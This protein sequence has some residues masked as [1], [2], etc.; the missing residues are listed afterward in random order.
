MKTTLKAFSIFVFIT[1]IQS[2]SGQPWQWEGDE[3]LNILW[4]TCEDISPTLSMYGDEVADTPNLDRL[5][6]EGMTYM[7]AFAVHGV[8]APARSCIATGMY[9]IHMGTN[10]MRTGS[11]GRTVIKGLESYEAVPP[12]EMRMVSELLRAN[13]YYATNN[14]KEDYQFKP[15]MT[16]WDE[17]SG[18]A[19]YKNRPEGKPFFA[20]FNIGITHESNIWRQAD[21]P[22]VGIDE[23]KIKIASYHPD[24][25]VVRNDY[26]IYY[27]NIHRMDQQ[28][29]EL[30][31]ELES[32][33]LLDNTI[34]FFYS[35]HGGNLPREKRMLFDSGLKVP[36]IVRFPDKF[37]QG[38]KTDRLV[39]FV[40]FAPTL[41]S[42]AGVEPK[43][44]MQGEA[45]LGDYREEEERQYIYA[46]R[47]RLD[48][49]PTDRQRAVR[50][51][52][53]K[54]IRNYN[55][56]HPNYLNVYY[57]YSIP[58]MHELLRLRE[59]GELTEAQARWF[60]PN[61]AVEEL[62]DT[63]LDPDEVNNLAHDKQ[64]WMK[65]DEMRREN[66]RFLIKTGDLQ[67]MPETRLRELFW[68][69]G[70]QP[71]TADPVIE[72]DD[73]MITLSSATR[74]ASIGYRMWERNAGKPES[75]QVYTGP[76]ELPRRHELE[77]RAHRIGYKPSEIIT[78]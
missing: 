65:L 48:E 44:W 10:H 6:R 9:P 39:S 19:H 77:V 50:D 5:A 47:D 62:Y 74:G 21:E 67:A 16:A 63:W 26:K 49:F 43:E 54:Y 78:Q 41:L 28:V 35:D 58:T 3:P 23:S 59:Q 4:I 73:G 8:C 52:R 46:A 25:P 68:P 57:R 69:N 36:L 22:F 51:K 31:D 18:Q 29:G 61:R 12:A 76:F 24:T 71:V 2:V 30:L 11:A 55:L 32:E 75:W 33:G 34:I 27:S 66:E 20:I 38:R 42:L 56:D 53:Y 14:S 7:N 40:D 13:G 64:Y 17:S 60:D 37:R 70:T 1:W 72:E 45:F 15:P